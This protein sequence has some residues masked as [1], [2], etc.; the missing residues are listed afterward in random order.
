MNRK[1]NYVLTGVFV[2][3]LGAAFIWGILWISAGGTPQQFDRYVAYMEESVSGLNVD[4][5]LKYRGVDVGKVEAISIDADNPQRI[6][7]LLQVRRGIPIT[8]D[9]VAMLEYQGVTG[10]ANVNL[11]GGRPGSPP[12]TARD[13]EDYPVIQTEPSLFT[14]L[15]TTTTDLLGN[16]IQTSASINALLSEENREH[17]ATTLENAAVLSASLAAQSRNFETALERLNETLRNT[18]VTSR[19]LPAMTE[20]LAAGAEL[21]GGM[22]RQL[23]EVAELAASIGADLQRLVERAGDDIDRVSAAA[24]PAF[25][26][27]L[28]DLRRTAQNLDRM[29]DQ[30]ASDPSVLFYGATP[31]QPGPGERQ[32]D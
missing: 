21:F 23:R 10:L 15:D 29:T 3:V 7:L 26:A 6:R 28:D 1:Q 22:A 8:V 5:A 32:D 4:S 16:L 11:I 9:T 14:R 2:I 17:I 19:D 20:D 25:A 18:S 12:L 13:D 30:L 27:M 31:P 24:A